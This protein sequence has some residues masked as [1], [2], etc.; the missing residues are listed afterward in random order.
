MTIIYLDKN[1]IVSDPTYD[2]TSYI[3]CVKLKNVL[4]GYYK[5]IV[6]RVDTG[7]CGVRNDFLTVIHYQ[8]VNDKLYWKKYRR[9]VDVD[10]GQAGIFDEKSYKNDASV[11][12]LPWIKKRAPWKYDKKTC[13]ELWCMKMADMTLN[14]KEKWGVYDN[15]VVAS[16]GLGDGT[17]PIYIAKDEKKNIIGIVIDFLGNNNLSKRPAHR[18]G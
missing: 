17:Y 4:P 1:V 3:E 5:V 16:S 9:S 2:D 10:S 7:K 14:S 11:A 18:K 6:R 15:G 13:G 8:H 12:F